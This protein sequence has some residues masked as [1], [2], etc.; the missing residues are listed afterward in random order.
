MAHEKGA[1]PH[2]G[3]GRHLPA[4]PWIARAHKDWRVWVAVVLMLAAML[5]YVLSFD[6]SL[7]PQAD[8]KQ[9]VPAAP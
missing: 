6:E 3:E 2:H 5:A 4:R 8:I 1:H 9:P 7:Q